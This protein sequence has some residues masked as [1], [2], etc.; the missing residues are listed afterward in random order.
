MGAGVGT[1]V[2]TVVGTD[3]VAGTG[4]AGVGWGGLEVCFCSKEF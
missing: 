2:G 3:V 1:E 4:A